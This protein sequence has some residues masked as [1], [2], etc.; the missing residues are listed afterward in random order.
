[1]FRL[2][3][4]YKLVTKE[5]PLHIHKLFGIICLVNYGYRYY[6]LIQNGSMDLDNHTATTLVL[7]HATLSCSSIL[8]HIPSIR[9]KSAP[10]IYPEYRLHSIIFVMRSVI[11]FF[12]TYYDCSILY[13]FGA[14]YLT[15]IMADIV[16]ARYR[17]DNQNTTMRDMPFDPRIKEDEQRKIILMQ[18][19]QQIGATLYMFGNLDSCFSPMFAIQLA[20]FLMTLVRKNIIDSN[21]WHLIYNVSLWM[22]AFCFYSIPVGYLFIEPVLFHIFYYWRFSVDKD[23]NHS[24]DK[25]PLGSLWKILVFLPLRVRNTSQFVGNKYVGWTI[26]FAIL[27]L[28]MQ[29]NVQILVLSDTAKLMFQ[30]SMIIAYFAIYIRKCKGFLVLFPTS[31]E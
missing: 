4:S 17:S 31:N 23:S 3:N 13:K 27:Y 1:M 25:N 14:C 20:A 16:T 19:S 15:M 7:C 12:L 26:V 8:F 28:Y 5:D 11:C 29:F 24:P 18:S 2:H 22:N 10:M 30:R 21:M 9:N 6:L